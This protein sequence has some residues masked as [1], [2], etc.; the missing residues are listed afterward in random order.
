MQEMLKLIIDKLDSLDK[1]Q[2]ELVG[3]VTTLEQGQKN[4][5]QGQK[6]LVGKV[7]T[8]EQGQKELVGKVTTMDKRL[9]RL[10]LRNDEMQNDVTEIR[11]VVHRLEENQPKDIEAILER[12]NNKVDDKCDALNKR[13]FEIETEIERLSRQ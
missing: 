9:N 12:I 6:E 4:L 10:E 3:K 7:T 13:V 11:K 8:L 5:E 1:G 2:K